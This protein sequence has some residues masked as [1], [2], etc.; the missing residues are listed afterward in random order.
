MARFS[1]ASGRREVIVRSSAQPTTLR[2]TWPP[3]ANACNTQP[4]LHPQDG[5]SARYSDRPAVTLRPGCGR[6][7]QLATR[8]AVAVLSLDSLQGAFEKIPLQGL[9]CNDPL[10]LINS[11]SQP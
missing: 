5:T 3:H 4:C 1:A 7:C 8:V 11:F 6:K 10:Q 2:H 9:V